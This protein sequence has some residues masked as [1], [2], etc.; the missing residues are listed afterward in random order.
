VFSVNDSPLSSREGKSLTFLLL[1]EMIEAEC[2]NNISMKMSPMVDS[3]G[4]EISG[5]G[6]LQIAILAERIRRKGFELT[7]SPPKV[8]FKTQQNGKL[9]E[10]VENII[11]DIP[12]NYQGLVLDMMVKRKGE[13]KKM[14]ESENQA[15]L[16]F[17]CPTR[18]LIGIAS[19]LKGETKGQ[20]VINRIFNGYRE[21]SGNIESGRKG[22]IISMADGVCTAYALNDLENRGNF[23]I[24]PGTVCYSGMII[25]ESNKNDDLEVNPCKQK[26]LSNVRSPLKDEGIKLASPIEMTAEEYISYMKGDEILEITPK[27]IRLRKSILNSSERRTA[28]KKLIN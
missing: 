20:A 8:I 6:E 5:R 9:L 18:G 21:H 24:R 19:H 14:N 12:S 28:K 17:T 2:E 11:I 15:R 26:V 4:V 25:G 27:S 22:C 3:K 10:P 23:F 16:E 1:K 13:L 7:L